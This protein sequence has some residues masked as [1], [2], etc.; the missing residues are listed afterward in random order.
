MNFSI[1]RI[2]VEC[3]TRWTRSSILALLYVLSTV[4]RISSSNLLYCSESTLLLLFIEFKS[5]PGAA[6]FQLSNPPLWQAVSL[7]GSLNVSTRFILPS[8]QRKWGLQPGA[9]GSW[10]QANVLTNQL[11]KNFASVI[12]KCTHFIRV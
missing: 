4:L 7:L 6:G 3:S 9:R 11:N 2:L 8:V 1:M 5:L 12:Y 10:Y